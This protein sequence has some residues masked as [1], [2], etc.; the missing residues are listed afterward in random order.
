MISA[1]RVPCKSMGREL[2]HWFVTIYHRYIH[3]CGIS[4]PLYLPPLAVSNSSGRC[5]FL[6]T[7]PVFIIECWQAWFFA[8]LVEVATVA[9]S[10]MCISH[11]MSSRQHF[12]AFIPTLQLLYSWPFFLDILSFE[13]I[14][15]PFREEDSTVTCCQRT[16]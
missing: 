3:H 13:G 11:V 1:F 6:W 9:M 10:S 5:E 7:P 4:L 15:V 2:F 8:C 12:A 16:D 14:N